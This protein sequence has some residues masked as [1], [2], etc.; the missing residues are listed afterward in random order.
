MSWER[1]GRLDSRAGCRE[2]GEVGEKSEL[3][4]T[5]KLEEENEMGEK[6]GGSR[7]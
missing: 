4:E 1:E 3:G 2:R 6:E 5:M 7:D